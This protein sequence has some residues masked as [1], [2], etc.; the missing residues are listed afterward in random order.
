MITQRP[1]RSGINYVIL[2]LLSVFLL[3]A[4]GKDDSSNDGAAADATARD[5]A[6]VQP[7]PTTPATPAGAMVDVHLT[8]YK[9]NMPSTLNAGPTDFTVTNDGTMQHTLEIK[10]NGVEAKLPEPLLAGEIR[11]L[12]VDLTPGTYTVYCPIEDHEKK[13]MTMQLTVQ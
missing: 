6:V 11:T 13:G 12:H 1:L 9:I 8:E 3:A 2:S 7:A 10:G 4:C 5:T